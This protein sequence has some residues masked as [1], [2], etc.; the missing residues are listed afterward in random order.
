MQGLDSHGLE[1]G[2]EVLE[3]LSSE[4][5][6]L[7]IGVDVQGSHLTGG[8]GRVVTGDRCGGDRDQGS[9]GVLGDQATRPRAAR[10]GVTFPEV[11]L[12]AGG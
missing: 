1:P 6:T 7:M 11:P 8:A 5:V 4:A 2:G 12:P 9:G 10:V 3:Q